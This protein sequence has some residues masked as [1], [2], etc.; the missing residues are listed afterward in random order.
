M[1]GWVCCCS[2]AIGAEAGPV[3]TTA[4]TTLRG[5]VDFVRGNVAQARRIQKPH[6]L[7]QFP[8]TSK[9]GG[10]VSAVRG[11]LKSWEPADNHETIDY[12]TGVAVEGLI[13]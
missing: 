7:L 8:A 11:R 12:P 2:S 13:S 9:I 6:I 10:K 1:G 4:G 3:Q 5:S